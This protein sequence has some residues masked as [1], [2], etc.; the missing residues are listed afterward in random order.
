MKKQMVAVVAEAQKALTGGWWDSDK[1]LKF[2]PMLFALVPA[3]EKVRSALKALSCKKDKD[4]RYRQG[5]SAL[6]SGR[7]FHN[8][9]REMEYMLERYESRYRKRSSESEGGDFREIAMMMMPAMMSQRG[10]TVTVNLDVNSFTETIYKECE[11]CP[12]RD[13]CKEAFTVCTEYIT[14]SLESLDIS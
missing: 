1:A 8:A 2:V 7:D 9:F 10:G 5:Q 14:T 11:K 6:E 3:D 12:I 13:V 4:Q